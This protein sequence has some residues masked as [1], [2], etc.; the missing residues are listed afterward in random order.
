MPTCFVSQPFDGGP[1]DARFDDTISPAIERAGF[2]PYRA[3][4]DRTA[5]I[6]IDRVQAAIFEADVVLADITGRNPNVWYEVGFAI[7]LDKPLILLS[8]KGKKPHL[9]FNIQH[10]QVLF[11]RTESLTDLRRLQDEVTE[12]LQLQLLA[13]SRGPAASAGPRD[14]A[15][16]RDMR[17]E[18]ELNR[19]IAE[20]KELM[21]ATEAKKEELFERVL[22]V[23]DRQKYSPYDNF[24][25]STTAADIERVKLD[26]A[27]SFARINGLGEEFETWMRRRKPKAKR[28]RSSTPNQAH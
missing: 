8:K 28:K 14:R 3:D 23:C 9:P 21:S 20:L 1:F 19:A 26:K 11:Y 4:R 7:A 24:D 17:P 5:A 22:L 12:R 6:P 25:D 18:L 27:T 13:E 2:T 10:R 15:V 16:S